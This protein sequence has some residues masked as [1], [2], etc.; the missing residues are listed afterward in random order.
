MLST[1]QATSSDAWRQLRRLPLRHGQEAEA[2]VYVDNVAVYL[3]ANSSASS[4]FSIDVGPVMAAGSHQLAI[5][6]YENDG[7][8][9][10]AF[11]N[12]TVR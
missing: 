10:V 12:I 9:V 1:R 2:R 4:S 6:F 8:A 5:V 7:S 11:V 3:A